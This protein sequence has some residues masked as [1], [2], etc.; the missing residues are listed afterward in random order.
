MSRPTEGSAS[1]DGS[2]RR[3]S[4]ALPVSADAVESDVR[5]GVRTLL[6]NVAQEPGRAPTDDEVG[7]LQTIDRL[8]SEVPVATVRTL[9]NATNEQVENLRMALGDSSVQQLADYVRNTPLAQAVREVE[10]VDAESVLAPHV[11]RQMRENTHC[12]SHASRLVEAMV[13]RDPA[14]AYGEIQKNVPAGTPDIAAAIQDADALDLGAATEW[15][16]YIEDRIATLR[17]ELT[18]AT[19]KNTAAARDL[20]MVSESGLATAQTLE[21]VGEIANS[22]PAYLR[23]LVLSCVP[24]IGNF[25]K[26]RLTASLAKG[27]RERVMR[28]Q[29]G[30]VLESLSET[31]TQAGRELRYT[32]EQLIEALENER[33]GP[34]SVWE[35][36]YETALVERA[37]AK[38][39]D[40]TPFAAVATLG[41]EARNL[42]INGYLLESLA[43][44]VLSLD[45]L[46]DRSA[47]GE[48]LPSEELVEAAGMTI[49]IRQANAK[50]DALNTQ[51][52]DIDTELKTASSAQAVQRLLKQRGEVEAELLTTQRFVE[53][54]SK[55][56]SRQQ[57]PQIGERIQR[58]VVLETI[59]EQQLTAM[60]D[61][62]DGISEALY[63][64]PVA[65]LIELRERIAQAQQR[66]QEQIKE[67][68]DAVLLQQIEAAAEGIP[69]DPLDA[70][71]LRER[72]PAAYDIQAL[73]GYLKRGG[74]AVVFSVYDNSTVKCSKGGFSGKAEPGFSILGQ[75][76][77]GDLKMA[78]HDRS[79]GRIPWQLFA[80]DISNV[81][82]GWA[83]NGYHTKFGKVMWLPAPDDVSDQD[84][85]NALSGFGNRH[86]VHEGGTNQC[87]TYS[88]N[89]Y[90]HATVASKTEA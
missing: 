37:A 39:K 17:N 84:L 75:P 26:K 30:N 29:L 48:K 83:I 90:A 54:E 16:E 45:A 46:L 15:R 1:D 77:L 44:E 34:T 61:A 40:L 85:A 57:L 66:A 76:R 19:E 47:D 59:P 81:S 23:D 38:A 10:S 72:L 64:M 68:L 4:D 6:A 8:F 80:K 82:G 14:E 55:E 88:T 49:S 51:I 24:D 42:M 7:K 73:E 86:N 11:A 69:T 3:S 33:R 28:Q 41:R 5:R 52:A 12:Y 53:R 13:G 65:R 43:T 31:V 18:S 89:V 20:Q 74:R 32:N 71:Q 58:D 78:I 60:R 79:R 9:V 35:K 36:K 50:I 87:C 70:R 67:R 21:D 62:Y 56:L 25:E 2:T 22:L 27:A 63:G